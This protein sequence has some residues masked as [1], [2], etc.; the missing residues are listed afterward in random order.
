V[1]ISGRP[2]QTE[3]GNIEKERYKHV[4]RDHIEKGTYNIGG[5]GINGNRGRGRE[6]Q[7][8]EAPPVD[9]RQLSGTQD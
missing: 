7:D 6:R 9:Q 8:E 5:E 1:I 2:R 3:K 4:R